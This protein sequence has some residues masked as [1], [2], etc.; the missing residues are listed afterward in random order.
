MKQKIISILL[1]LIATYSWAQDKS[2]S[3]SDE[4]QRIPI[5]PIVVEGEV[6]GVPDGTPVDICFRVRKTNLFRNPELKFLADNP[7][8]K[9]TMVG[10]AT[11]T[12]KNLKCFKSLF[13]TRR[14]NS[15]KPIDS[16]FSINYL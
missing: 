2:T 5:K 3:S 8:T 13:K 7:S 10:I 12:E 15:I 9:A 1:L 11:N 14:Q 16:C 4:K 6:T